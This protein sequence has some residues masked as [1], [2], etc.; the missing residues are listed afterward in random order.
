LLPCRRKCTRAHVEN[1]ARTKARQKL[2]PPWRRCSAAL[3]LSIATSAASINWRS[4][5]D[6]C[7]AFEQVKSIGND[8]RRTY[9]A[10]LPRMATPFCPRSL[11]WRTVQLL[12]LP[13]R[14]WPSHR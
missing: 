9:L 12:R 7:N 4:L 11:R 5:E 3:P 1:F 8:T 10:S 6:V 2:P 14:R 13:A